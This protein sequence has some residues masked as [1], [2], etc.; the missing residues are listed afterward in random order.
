MLR[1]LRDKGLRLD[2]SLLPPEVDVYVGDLVAE[3]TGEICLRH[4]DAS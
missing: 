4:V 3:G 2:E 1:D